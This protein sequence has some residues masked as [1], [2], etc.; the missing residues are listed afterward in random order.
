MFLYILLQLVIFIVK[1]I[2]RFLQWTIGYSLF[3]GRAKDR[4]RSLNEFEFCAHRLKIAARAKLIEI[5]PADLTSF[6]LFH[7]SY[8]DPRI[9][10]LEN[11]DVILINVDKHGAT[12]GVFPGLGPLDIVITTVE[13]LQIQYLIFLIM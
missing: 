11:A 10:I 8:E 1:Y 7:S 12:F 9:A 5:G 3:S 13:S 4:E 2:S 6:L